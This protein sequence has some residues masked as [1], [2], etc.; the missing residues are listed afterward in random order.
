MKVNRLRIDSDRKRK[1]AERY[2]RTVR[3]VTRTRQLG[4]WLSKGLSKDFLMHPQTVCAMKFGRIHSQFD[5]NT[6]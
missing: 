6:W 2:L 4:A 1:T 3:H 5:G